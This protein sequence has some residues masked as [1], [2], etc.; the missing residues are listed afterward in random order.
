MNILKQNHGSHFS[1]H[2]FHS[3]SQP[4]LTQGKHF[5]LKVYFQCFLTHPC[6]CSTCLS[7]FFLF[8]QLTK[9]HQLAMQQSPFPIA[10]SNQGFQGRWTSCEGEFDCCLFLLIHAINSLSCSFSWDGCLCTNWLSW[11]DH[12]K[13]CKSWLMWLFFFFLTEKLAAF[14][15][16]SFCFNWQPFIL[17]YF[18]VALKVLT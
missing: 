11:A 7:F 1:F 10:H 8:Q 14:L 3:L 2:D 18:V 17:I 12:S 16:S 15:S 5:S 4:P 6:L 13:R 9:L